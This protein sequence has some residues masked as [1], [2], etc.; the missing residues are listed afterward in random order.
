MNS[1]TNVNLNMKIYK[2]YSL[3]S[4]KPVLLFW[5][6]CFYILSSCSH[7]N[8]SSSSYYTFKSVSGK[9]DYT[10]LDYWAAHPYKLDPSDSVPLPLKN[11]LA[12]DSGIDVFFLYPTSYTDNSAIA[13]NASIDDPEINAKT[14]YSSILYQASVFNVQCRIF[15][16]RYRQAH[17]RAFYVPDSV[18][19]PYFDLA[20]E[21]IKAAFEEYL[22]SYNKGR[23]II[24]A[25]HSQGTLH[26]GRL[27][28]EFF[29]NKPLQKQLVC[30]YLIG[31]PVPLS[32]FSSL[33]P[34]KDSS[35]TGCLISWRSFKSGYSG[36]S[37]IIKE[38]AEMIVVNPLS[39]T[40]DNAFV[41]AMINKGGVLRK[42]NRL[43]PHV[44]S[45][46]VH[47][48]ILWTS[49]PDM[50]G[51]ILLTTKNYHVGDINLF[52]LNIRENLT[53]RIRS[54]KKMY[55]NK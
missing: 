30:A 41:P 43:V 1:Q 55:F 49:K 22:K 6:F 29:D 11:T 38:K 34:C 52:Y 53:T 45:A 36:D 27:L 42:F 39:W 15:S 31:M 21:D 8:F 23:P 47:H 35:S 50:P 51:K 20:F 17:I 18:S 2:T 12:A 3:F 44:V 33:K 26:A 5:F 14:D 48:N 19:K 54:Y 28:R 32:Y 9:P 25:S 13:W 7:K 24:I 4:I 16:P 46:Q 37:V 40:T 10:N